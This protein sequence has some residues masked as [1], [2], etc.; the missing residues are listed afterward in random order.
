MNYATFSIKKKTPNPF[1]PRKGLFLRFT[2]DLSATPSPPGRFPAVQARLEDRAGYPLKR[3][4]NSVDPAK[5]KSLD[6]KEPRNATKWLVCFFVLFFWERFRWK[7]VKLISEVV[8][9]W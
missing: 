7:V 8:V 6:G 5:W 2:T 9:N 1:W 3:A 4:K